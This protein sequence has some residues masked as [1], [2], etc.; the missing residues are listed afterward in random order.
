MSSIE[1]LP[2]RREVLHQIQNLRLQIA[3][4]QQS[5]VQINQELHN[6]QVML[7][8]IMQQ[9]TLQQAKPVNDTGEAEDKYFDPLNDTCDVEVMD[10]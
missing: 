1:P 5:Q 6:V 2:T 4:L 7:H 8:N 3:N 10:F 9:A